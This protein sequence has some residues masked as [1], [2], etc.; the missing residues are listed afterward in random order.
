MGISIL[1]VGGGILW[2]GRFD[3]RGSGPSTNLVS[4]SEE[5]TVELD[6][7]EAE[8]GIEDEREDAQEAL[9][10]ASAEA[11]DTAPNLVGGADKKE[12][13]ARASASEAGGVVAC[14]AC[15][16]CSQSDFSSAHGAPHRMSNH[17]LMSRA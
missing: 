9:D 3:G 2:M 1:F 16:P 8:V 7:S 17:H 12:L 11:S 5:S 4:N 6:G 10:R 13:A 15:A 14:V